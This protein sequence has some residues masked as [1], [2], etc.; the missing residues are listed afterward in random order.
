MII[1]KQCESHPQQSSSTIEAVTVAQEQVT[2]NQECECAADGTV[3]AGDSS[4]S[5]FS[6]K[7]IK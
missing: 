7:N 4:F 2:G 1:K 6:T 3:M 5:S